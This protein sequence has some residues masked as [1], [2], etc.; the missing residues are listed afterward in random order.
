MVPTSYSVCN[1][2]YHTKFINTN[3]FL[4]EPAYV[5]DEFQILC[6]DKN[7]FS[8]LVMIII[9]CF[10]QESTH[11]GYR[12]LYKVFPNKKKIYV[13]RIATSDS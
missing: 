3:V 5:Y 12:S 1:Y 13:L 10:I 4:I 6:V 2:N 9:Q 8:D 7:D 11:K